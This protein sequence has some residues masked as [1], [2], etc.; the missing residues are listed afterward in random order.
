MP[1]AQDWALTWNEVT[2]DLGEAFIVVS[3]LALLVSLMIM[4]AGLGPPFN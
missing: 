1:I 2:R 4:L 3:A